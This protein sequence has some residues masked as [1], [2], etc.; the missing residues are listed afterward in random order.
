MSDDNKQWAYRANLDRAI[1][2]RAYWKTR[3]GLEGFA[4]SHSRTDVPYYS[5]E[6]LYSAYLIPMIEHAWYKRYDSSLSHRLYFGLGNKWEKAFSSQG[7]WYIRYE[8]DYKFSQDFN[9]MIGAIYSKEDYYGED[10]DVWNFYTTF[11][12]HF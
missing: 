9:L 8:H 3:I 1:T 12:K 11:K 2:T 4:I 5:P 6:Y 7:V 10:T